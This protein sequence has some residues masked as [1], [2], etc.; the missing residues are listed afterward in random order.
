MAESRQRDMP[1]V[2]TPVVYGEHLYMWNDNGVVVCME[3]SSGKDV[4]TKRIGGNFSGSPIGI[5]GKLYC[6]SEAGDVHVIAASPE[7]QDFGKT[8]LGDPSH[9]TPARTRMAC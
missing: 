9:A 2:P 5:D 3:L 7:F 1:Y 8:P 6:I 4:W